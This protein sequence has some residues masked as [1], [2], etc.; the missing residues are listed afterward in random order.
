MSL[1]TYK[2]VNSTIE[3]VSTSASLYKAAH[4][5]KDMKLM[6]FNSPIIKID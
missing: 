3:K 6:F 4:V 1:I 5:F 2:L